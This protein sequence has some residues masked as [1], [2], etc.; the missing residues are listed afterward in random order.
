MKLIYYFFNI[1]L[2]IKFLINFIIN[3][4]NQIIKII[5]INTL[6]I[7]LIIFYQYFIIFFLYKNLVFYFN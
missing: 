3:L 5:L 4:I 2:M 1:F 6:K 7:N